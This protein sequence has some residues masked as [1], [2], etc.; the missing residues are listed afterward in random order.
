MAKIRMG[1]LM[2]YICAIATVL[3]IVL[4][5]INFRVFVPCG[6]KTTQYWFVDHVADI[7]LPIWAGS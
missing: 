3:N 5:Y 6:L 2:L 4:T 7:H 1:G